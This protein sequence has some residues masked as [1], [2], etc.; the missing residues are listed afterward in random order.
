MSERRIGFVGAGA[1]A[2]YHAFA[3]DA[4]RH[5]Y[6]DQPRIVPVAISSASE[7]SRSQAAK[8]YGFAHAVTTDEIVSRDDLDSVYVFSPNALHTDHLKL[9]LGM[10][11]VERVYVEKPICV[12]KEEEDEL[13]ALFSDASG[14]QTVQVGFQ[15]LQMSCVRQALRHREQLGTPIHFSARYLHS[16][17]LDEGYRSKRTERLKPAPIGG[18]TADLGSHAFSLLIAFL[19]EGLEV[20]AALPSGSFSDVPPDS[21]LCSTVLLRD[22]ASGAVGTLVASR[23]S[24]GAGDALDLEIRGTTGALRLSTDR[25]DVLEV[26]GAGGGWSV[27]DCGNDYRP[28]T[29]FPFAQTPSGWLRSLIH[30]QYLFFGGEDPDAFRPGPLHGLATQRLIRKTADRFAEARSGI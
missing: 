22:E 24:A 23:V 27:I 18:A 17:Y 29:A 7:Q 28:A 20:E 11:G 10:P 3:L 9:A 5:Y 4:L 25:P 8:R 2:R 26:S 19:G 21:D 14:G 6:S 16:G 1:I 13:S 15:F 12:T 30:A